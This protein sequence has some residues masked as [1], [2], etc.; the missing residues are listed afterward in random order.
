MVGSHLLCL[1]LLRLSLRN[2]CAQHSS[3][4]L[5]L[6]LKLRL[7]QGTDVSILWLLPSMPLSSHL[8]ESRSYQQKIHFWSPEELSSVVTLHSEVLK[9]RESLCCIPATPALQQMSLT[10]QDFLPLVTGTAR[11]HLFLKQMPL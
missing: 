7:W 4:V 9:G 3:L 6:P 8:C 5:G 11:H 10:T 1:A 2:H